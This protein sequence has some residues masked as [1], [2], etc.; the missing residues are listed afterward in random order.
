MTFSL[1]FVL[2]FVHGY[3]HEPFLVTVRKGTVFINLRPSSNYSRCLRSPMSNWFVYK[4]KQTTRRVVCSTI[5]T[6]AESKHRHAID[7]LVVVVHCRR[8]R[9]EGGRG[10]CEAE[11]SRQTQQQWWVRSAANPPVLWWL[12]GRRRSANTGTKAVLSSSP[13]PSILDRISY[14]N[15][16]IQV[17]IEVML[18]E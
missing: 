15:G 10:S 1:F 16:H 13:C 3:P 4:A 11:L 5:K 6:K 7:L 8:R 9:S 2:F 12:S 18:M 14:S 17:D